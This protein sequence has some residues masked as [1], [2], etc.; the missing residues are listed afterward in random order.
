MY[1]YSVWLCVWFIFLGVCQSSVES[2]L[3]SSVAEEEGKFSEKDCKNT[4]VP[5]HIL[6]TVSKTLFDRGLYAA[7]YKI[8]NLKNVNIYAFEKFASSMFLP[9]MNTFSVTLV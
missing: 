4:A 1:K 5:S 8:F 2:G 7:N 6:P 9:V 3:G